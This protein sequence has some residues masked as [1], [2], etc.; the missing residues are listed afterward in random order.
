MS[1]VD[2]TEPLPQSQSP[3]HIC[4]IDLPEYVEI[5]LEGISLSSSY[6]KRVMETMVNSFSSTL[7]DHGRKLSAKRNKQEQMRANSCEWY[8]I[9][10]SDSLQL[11]SKHY[12]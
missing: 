12:K 9:W 7:V 4:S 6:S 3:S 1:V 10:C 11:N 8:N 5:F 2:C